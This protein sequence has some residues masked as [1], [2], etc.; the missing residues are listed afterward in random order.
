MGPSYKFLFSETDFDR[1][2]KI[3]ENPS[4][5]KRLINN[6]K[7]K[8]ILLWRGKVLF[9]FSSENP[10][11]GLLSHNDKFW[12]ASN[13]TNRDHGNFLG[14]TNETALFYHD[15]PDWNNLEVDEQTLTGFSDETRTHHPA[16]PNNFSFC[17]LRSLMTLIT[18][19][20]ASVLASAKGI[21]EWNKINYFCNKCGTKTIPTLSGWEKVCDVCNTKHFPRTDPVVIMMVYH[22]EMALLAR[23]AAWPKRMFSC[24][25]GFMEPGES[26]E[27]AVSRETF[28]ETGI[29][30]KNSKYVTSQP[31]P[32]PSSLMIGCIAEA[33]SYEI[34]IDEDELEDAR[35]FSRKEINQ[36]LKSKD[37]WWPAR[38][39]SIARFLINQW[40]EGNI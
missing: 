5:L 36:A 39:G 7:T 6:P 35:W 10:C 16:L 9:D 14:F 22:K 20:D 2:T 1:S 33:K 11:I 31:W 13:N 19:S 24:L 18:K 25:A 27:A 40:V 4:E 37:K 34:S 32:F 3:R 21:Y 12:N 23:S 8:H 17:E 28:E 38:E 26:I 29:L 15:I 30:V